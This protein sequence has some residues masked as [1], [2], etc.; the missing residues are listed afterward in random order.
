[1]WDLQSRN[2][3]NS[4]QSSCHYSL[5]SDVDLIV[6]GTRFPVNRAYLSACSPVFAAMFQSNMKEQNASEVE[7]KEVDS[8][9]LFED[10]LRALLPQ[11]NFFP[12][13]IKN[14]INN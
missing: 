3:Q 1:M 8:A 4:R 13:R 10:F 14:L 5:Q 2:E 6:R 9:E 11:S 7:I 12:N